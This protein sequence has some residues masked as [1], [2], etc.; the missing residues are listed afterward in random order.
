MAFF[1]PF[2]LPRK[3]AGW[4]PARRAGRRLPG[5]RGRSIAAGV[6]PCL[7]AALDAVQSVCHPWCGADA[8]G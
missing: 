7:R 2:W 3:E 6:F 4:K 1:F 8:M 5:L